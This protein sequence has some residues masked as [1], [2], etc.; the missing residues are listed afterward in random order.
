MVTGK[1]G[2]TPATM[3]ISTATRFVV[4][5]F[6]MI[7]AFLLAIR[8][9]DPNY[10]VDAKKYWQSRLQTLVLPFLVWNVIYMLVEK[11]LWDV[12]IVSPSTAFNLATGYFNCFLSLCCYNA[13]RF[14]R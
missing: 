13:W 6:F 1:Y 14:T 3:L 5:V 2:Y 12:P 11:D 9:R 7:S 10:S 4:P 8:H